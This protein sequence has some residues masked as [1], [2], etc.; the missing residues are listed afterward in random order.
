MSALTNYAENKVVDA[1]LRGQPLGAPST[2][3]LALSTAPRSDAGAPVEP[4]GNGYARVAIAANLTSFS[5]TQGDTSISSGTDGTVENLAPVTYPTS[6]GAWAGGA[7][8][9]SVWFM[10]AASGGNPWLS[11]NMSNPVA[12]SATGYT[13]TFA[14]GQLTFQIDNE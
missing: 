14:N 5:S 4:S 11:F 10:D 8:L 1:I 9:E 13:L 12:V 3:Y 7:N 2:L 6:T